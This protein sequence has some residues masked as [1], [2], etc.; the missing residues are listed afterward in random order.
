MNGRCRLVRISL[1]RSTP[2]WQGSG[3]S[4]EAD[5]ESDQHPP[6]SIGEQFVGGHHGVRIV[7]HDLEDDDDGKYQG[8]VTHEWRL[9]HLVVHEVAKLDEVADYRTNEGTDDQ[10]YQGGSGEHVRNCSM[11]QT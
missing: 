6:Q 7:R 10:R 2:G 4:E 8:A 3:W 5:Q 11:R 1:I 9:H